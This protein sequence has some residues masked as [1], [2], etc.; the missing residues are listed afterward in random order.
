MNDI[1]STRRAINK[2]TPHTHLDKNVKDWEVRRQKQ[3]TKNT[4]NKPTD[5]EAHGGAGGAGLAG[6][7]LSDGLKRCTINKKHFSQTSQQECERFCSHAAK[8]AHQENLQQDQNLRGARTRSWRS[9]RKSPSV[10]GRCRWPEALLVLEL[11]V[12][13]D[14]EQPSSG[15]RPD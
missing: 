9:W 8:A 15:Q 12:S 1:S 13:G 4:C 2:N 5:S 14:L 3:L 10:H 7:A 11:L 6:P